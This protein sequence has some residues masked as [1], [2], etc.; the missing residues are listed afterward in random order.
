[1]PPCFFMPLDEFE[2]N[3]YAVEMKNNICAKQIIFIMGIIINRQER[4]SAMVYSNCK[5]SKRKN[6]L[7]N[8]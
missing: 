8:Y 7:Y 2:E 3:Q 5:N 4:Y 1:M 6:V